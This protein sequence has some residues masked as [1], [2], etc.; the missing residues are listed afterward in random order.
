[1][2]EHLDC[3]PHRNLAIYSSNFALPEHL[4]A[5]MTGLSKHAAIHTANM[6]TLAGGTWTPPACQ[7]TSQPLCSAAGG[8][9]SPSHMWTLEGG[10]D[11]LIVG[12]LQAR[13]PMRIKPLCADVL[14]L[15][16]GIS[17]RGTPFYDCKETLWR[18]L[19]LCATNVC[20]RSP[21]SHM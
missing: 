16:K 8:I 5:S 7:I 21:Q 19:D 18:R 6:C 2:K 1:M 12:L 13:A 3:L 20:A 14:S 10:L 11:L 15:G 4:T 17:C 9:W